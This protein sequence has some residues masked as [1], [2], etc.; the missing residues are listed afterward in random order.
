MTRRTVPDAGPCPHHGVA[1]RPIMSDAP[2]PQPAELGRQRW[3]GQ[4]ARRAAAAVRTRGRG[5]VAG[6]RQAAHPGDQLVRVEASATDVEHARLDPLPIRAGLQPALMPAFTDGDPLPIRSCCRHAGIV[7]PPCHPTSIQSCG[8]GRHAHALGPA[9]IVVEP[10][11]CRVV[12]HGGH[13]AGDRHRTP[14]PVGPRQDSAT[15]RPPSRTP[16]AIA[17]SHPGTAR[18]RIGSTWDATIRRRD[19]VHRPRARPGHAIAHPTGV[20]RSNNIHH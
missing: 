10:D 18:S 2:S 19:T 15:A 11:R 1:L 6:L 14:V 4:A 17:G 8:G 13:G 5:A 20:R 9:A 7:S 16:G 3:L 12:V